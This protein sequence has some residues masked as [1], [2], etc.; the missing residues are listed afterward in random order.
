MGIIKKNKCILVISDTHFP[1]Q[2]PDTILFLAALK[3][4][5]KFDRVVHIGDEI[6]GHAISFHN[7]DPD[8]ISPSDEF[9]LSIERLQPLYELFPKVDVI[10]S[11]HGSLV[12][13]KGKALGLPRHVFKS[14]REIL[15]APK[16]W[17]WHFDLTITA[18]DNMPIYFCHG[19]TSSPGRLSK[20]MGMKTVQGHYHEKFE[21]IYWANPTGLYWDMRVG[22]LVHDAS[23]AFA[24]NNT[25]LQRP[26]IGTGIILD[27]QPKLMP[28][29]LDK[30]GRWIGKLK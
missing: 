18:S 20:S 7:H 21:I 16:G 10:E 24:Y 23:R 27:G 9:Q 19:K 6:D 25:N 5:Y 29:I 11:N 14:Y 8:L 2:H 17:S 22:C 13:R 26:I 28:M 30:R 12:Y 15:K 4:E 1:Y 3:S